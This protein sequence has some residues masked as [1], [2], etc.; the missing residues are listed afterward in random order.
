MQSAQRNVRGDTMQISGKHTRVEVNCML[1]PQWV[2]MCF[3]EKLSQYI[4]S[5]FALLLRLHRGS[6]SC[7][8]SLG[9]KTLENGVPVYTMYSY[10]SHSF[11]NL[12]FR[13]NNQLTTAVIVYCVQRARTC[14]KG[15]FSC[16]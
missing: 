2:K 9:Y 13:S 12:V 15:V 6:Y 4:R 1:W 3:R 8:A 14:N 5:L 10:I 11:W 7:T 16:N